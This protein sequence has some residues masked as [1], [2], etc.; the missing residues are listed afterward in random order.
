MWAAELSRHPELLKLSETRIG[1]KRIISLP[2]RQSVAN[3]ELDEE[4]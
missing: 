2:S 1:Q 3:G 4:E